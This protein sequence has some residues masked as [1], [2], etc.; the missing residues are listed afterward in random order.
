MPVFLTKSCQNS[1]VSRTPV[2]STESTSLDASRSF[3][4]KC[5]NSCIL[6]ILWYPKSGYR[7][8]QNQPSIWVNRQA[9]PRQNATRRRNAFRIQNGKSW[10]LRCKGTLLTEEKPPSPWSGHVCS[11]PT[12]TD[13]SVQVQISVRNFSKIR[14]FGLLY[15]F[16]F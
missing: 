15:G 13:L 7:V 1:T 3:R 5:R 6:I 2:F 10:P 16:F 11:V 14:I 8:F 4:P 12:R 9:D